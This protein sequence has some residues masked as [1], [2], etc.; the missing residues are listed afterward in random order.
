MAKIALAASAAM[1]GPT[2]HD[3]PS[4]QTTTSNPTNSA[5]EG[6]IFE[7]LALIGALLFGV[8]DA[9]RDQLLRDEQR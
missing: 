3:T 6:S 2:T 1:R 9:T 7:D 8:D 4:R 5:H